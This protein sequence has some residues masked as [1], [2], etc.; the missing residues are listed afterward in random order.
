[1]K[2]I[3]VIFLLLFL[4][5]GCNLYNNYS[6]KPANYINDNTP[7]Y[8]GKLYNFITLYDYQVRVPVFQSIIPEGWK[9]GITSNWNNISSTSPGIETVTIASPDNRAKIVFVSQ[10]SFIDSDHN[11]EGINKDYYTTYF[12]FIDANYFLDY[13]ISHNYGDIEVLKTVTSDNDYNTILELRGY[14][15]MLVDAQKQL[16]LDLGTSNYGMD[17]TVTPLDATIAKKQ[18]TIGSN[19]IE[20]STAVTGY[21]MVNKNILYTQTDKE[22]FA[23]YTIVYMAEDEDA[24]NDYYD[25]YNF[26]VANSSFT[27]KFYD[28]LSYVSSAIQNVYTAYYAEKSKAGLNA[29]N[30]FI[31]SNY[32]STSSASTNEKVMEMWDDVIKEVDAYR[33]EDGN[34][35]KTSIY[36]EAV[37]QNG[38]QIYIGD[39]AG[40]PLGFNQLGKAY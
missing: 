14:T 6:R 15:N 5:T 2:K 31:D 1:M 30:N 23:P 9:S 24:F 20:G 4:L 11:P 17:I 18:Y 25:D 7:T 27:V 40:I 28:M 3:V 37:A 33:T 8:Q 26:I 16:A 13:Y 29:L 36:D 12:R 39:K 10:Q 34:V 22:W 35:I 32:S 38:N 19:I 21:K